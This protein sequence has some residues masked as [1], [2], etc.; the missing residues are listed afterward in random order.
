MKKETNE[1]KKQTNLSLIFML[2]FFS[3]IKLEIM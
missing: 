3:Q 1:K 2:F